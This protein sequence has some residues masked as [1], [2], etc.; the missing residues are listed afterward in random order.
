MLDVKKEFKTLRLH[1]MAHAWDA[2]LHPKFLLLNPS[3]RKTDQIVI[4]ALA[5]LLSSRSKALDIAVRRRKPSSSWPH[6]IQNLA[7]EIHVLELLPHLIQIKAQQ[8]AVIHLTIPRSEIRSVM[9]PG[10]AELNAIVKAQGLGP[11]GPWFSHHLAMYPDTFDFEI[12]VPVSSPVTP[13]LRVKPSQLPAARVARATLMGDYSGLPGGW[14]S[15][16]DWVAAHGL[17]VAPDLWEV[18]VK[19]PESG[20]DPAAW[21][22]E[23]NQPLLD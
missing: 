12:G 20:P 19:G 16:L 15:L 18:Y 10:I 21:R 8:T 4:G 3:K 11:T 14:S 23:L 5:N 13:S 22:T 9:G 1:G 2:Y 17:S 6:N 7:K